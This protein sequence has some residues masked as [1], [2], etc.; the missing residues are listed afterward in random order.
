[1]RLGER[2]FD[3]DERAVIDDSAGYPERRV[4]W[5]WSAA[6]GTTTDG[7]R[8]AWNLVTGIHDSPAASERTIWLDG[9]PSEPAAVTFA[10]DLSAIGFAD[11][12]GVDFHEESVRERD[13]NRL[14]FKSFYAQP[15]GTFT[16]T[17][18]DGVAIAE[19][20]GVMERHV[21]KW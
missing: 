21:V 14:V 9:E 17:L 4:S 6:V 5:L 10:Q 1:V 2:H 20:Y 7:R 8:L 12:S 16:G 15:F 3:V 13:E 18:P 11:G 19:A